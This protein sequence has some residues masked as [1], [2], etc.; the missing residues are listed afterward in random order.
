MVKQKLWFVG[1]MMSSV[2]AGAFGCAVEV[3]DGA[4]GALS[5]GEVAS[6]NSE[7]LI[8]GWV[9]GPYTWSQNARPR[10]LPALASDV[11]V[12]TRLTGKFSGHGEWV[13]V[14]DDGTNWYLEGNSQQRDVAGEAY[15]FKRA[16]L[17]GA[18]ANI[19]ISS[20]YEQWNPGDP[21][22]CGRIWQTDMYA[23][24]AFAFLSGVQGALEGGDEHIAVQQAL[25]T[26]LLSYVESAS[27][28]EGGLTAFAR[29]LRVGT[30]TARLA[31]FVGA[32]RYG[33]D[34]LGDANVVPPFMAGGS[35]SSDMVV[36][37]PTSKAL[38][39]FTLIQGEFE[40]GGEWIQMRPE[41]VD[42]VERWVLRT[43]RAGGSNYVRA[44]ARCFA[45]DQRQYGAF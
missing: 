17:I 20:E 6:T 36:M 2:A 35:A 7:A 15:C 31:K 21:R 39:A 29:N 45:R 26:D 14:T 44:E 30:R 1:S 43:Q 32:S 34:R 3:E 18:D 22:G 27:C 42:G 4:D 23:S 41:V 5:G 10:K 37:A 11:C 33:G 9:S 19:R 28:A 16:N 13:K 8:A 40:G 25:S 38:C 12:L 24:D